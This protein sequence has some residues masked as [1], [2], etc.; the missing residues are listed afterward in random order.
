MRAMFLIS[1]IFILLSS[2]R[3]SADIPKKITY[4][5]QVT[6]IG[7]TPVANGEYTMRFQ[8]YDVSSGGTS[9]WD[10]GNRTVSITNGLFNI[11]LG[12]SPQPEIDLAFDEDYWLQITFAGDVQNPRTAFGSSGYAYMA[13]G[14]VPGTVV[15]GDVTDLPFAV[16][17]VINTSTSDIHSAGE[18]EHMST[19]GTGVF[20]YASASTGTTYGVIGTSNSIAGKGV[21]GYSTSST[22]NA[23]AGWFKGYSTSGTAVYGITDPTTGNAVGIHGVSNSNSGTGVY[24]EAMTGSGTAYGVRGK[25][26]STN[27]YAGY[28]EGRGYFSG[29]LGLGTTSP[30]ASLTI[31]NVGTDYNFGNSAI[32]YADGNKY[33]DF[34]AGMV[35]RGTGGAWAAR[36]TGTSGM[37]PSGEILGIYKE[38]TSPGSTLNTAV[39]Q[40]T[41]AV[42]TNDGSVGIGTSSN[43]A[44]GL[45]LKTTNPGG[46]GYTSLLFQSASS[47]T[48]YIGLQLNSNDDLTI[49][50]YNGGWN[51]SFTLE[52]ATG[53]FGFGSGM[54]NPQYLLHLNGGA[55]SDGSSWMDASTKDRK[56]DTRELNIDEA[57]EALSGLDPIVYREITNTDGDYKVGFNAE[58]VPELVA[59]SSRMG[60]S[61]MEFVAVLTKIIQHQQKRIDQLEKQI[62][63]LE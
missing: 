55:Y 43:L 49:R 21:C 3:L 42:F 18:F 28:F 26:Y 9:I 20:G 41:I 12:E 38:E 59:T 57:L 53:H 56:T 11:L 16:L 5:G 50:T 22:G 6:D 60:L 7:G 2:V 61:S 39:P 27:A 63:Q 8:I 31:D 47:T 24:G 45:T 58:D 25:V 40:G 62:S 10:S 19:S 15:M 51:D 17:R 48:D 13:S 37:D 1:I 29:N 52:H 30:T 33:F 44:P 54:T 32:Y 34:T 4:Q 23:Y 14:L 46:W 35:L 36:F